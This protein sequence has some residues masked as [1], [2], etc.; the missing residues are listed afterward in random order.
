M[1]VF[2]QMLV[3]LLLIITGCILKKLK[4]VSPETKK[5]MSSLVVNIFNPCLIVSSVFGDPKGRDTSMVLKVFVIAAGVFAV[6]IVLGKILSRIG[7]KNEME[8]RVTELMYVFS[9]LGF[10]GIPVV[11]ALLG[12]TYV[13][14]VAIFILVYTVLFYTYGF[15]LLN[16]DKET[17]VSF[18]TTMRR[19]FCNIGTIASIIALIIFFSGITV[20]YVL[21]TT[22]GYLSN[23]TTPMSLLVIGVTIGEQ[24]SLRKIFM[25]RRIYIFTLLKM[26]VIPFGISIFLHF[27]PVPKEIQILTLIMAAMPVG[28]MP[29]MLLD[30]RGITFDFCSDGI[31]MTTVVSVLTIPLLIMLF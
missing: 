3:I 28:S 27:F 25:D 17:H 31:I 5:T 16:M 9:N 4:M 26:F 10:I 20:P 12:D 21:S 22:I 13:I 1:I 7:K 6:L 14:Y 18:R 24:E 29:Q 8:R 15:S 11:K 19:V 30:D 23:M 2:E